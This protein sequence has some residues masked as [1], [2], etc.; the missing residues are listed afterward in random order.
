MI[1]AETFK[2]TKITSTIS[3][4]DDLRA[5]NTESIAK[6]S[7]DISKSQSEIDFNTD[8][9]DTIMNVELDRSSILAELS[10]QK[11]REIAIDE[12]L[13]LVFDTEQERYE[14]LKEFDQETKALQKLQDDQAYATYLHNETKQ[15]TRITKQLKSIV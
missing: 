11:Q 12:T 15:Q 14:S 10:A 5:K 6:K 1:E 13:A 7:A 8:R 4:N 3:K 9:L 2:D